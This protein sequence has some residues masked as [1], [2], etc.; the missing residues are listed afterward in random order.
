MYSITTEEKKMKKPFEVAR[1]ET[2]AQANAFISRVATV[3]RGTKK[4]RT[5]KHDGLE[6]RLYFSDGK[7]ASLL[8]I[9][10]LFPAEGF[11]KRKAKAAK[12]G[13]AA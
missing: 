8:V 4:G 7:L 9:D 1:V 3:W 10:P 2:Q 5:A 6:T 13:G 11:P 12:E